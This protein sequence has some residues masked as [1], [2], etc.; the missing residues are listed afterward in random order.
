METIQDLTYAT[1]CQIPWNKDRIIGPKPP[2]KLNEIRAIRIR[3]QH[4]LHAR[5][6][7]LFQFGY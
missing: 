1:S 7:A 6:L 5:N 3:V 2:L 4:T